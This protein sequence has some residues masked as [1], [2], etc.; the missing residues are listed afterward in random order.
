MP[1]LTD[2]QGTWPFL[3][4]LVLQYPWKPIS[5]SDDL[6]SFVYVIVQCALR[7]HAHNLGSPISLPSTLTKDQLA[8]HNLKYG[9]ELAEFVS[10][11]FYQEHDKGSYVIGGAAKLVQISSSSP[12][13]NLVQVKRRSAIRMHP[14]QQL[15]NDLYSLLHEHYA[16]LDVATLARYKMENN[17]WQEE[18][19]TARAF[20]PQL[21][22]RR[23]MKSTRS[24]AARGLFSVADASL[25]TEE[26][27]VKW[28][29]EAKPELVL[30]NHDEILEIF[31]AVITGMSGGPLVFK[32][33]TEDQLYGTAE[34][35]NERPTGCS[36]AAS[37][38]RKSDATLE[39]RNAKHAR[40]EETSA[41]PL[42]TLE[43]D[44][45]DPRALPDADNVEDVRAESDLTDGAEA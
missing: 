5:L 32:D 19:P 45:K 1:F 37:S 9:S 27:L 42:D 2:V 43:E 36:G 18:D 16:A 13:F 6:E 44:G 34:V 39:G 11:L 35:V 25:A 8:V 3:S 15:L 28:Q 26:Y 12:G 30:D 29:G 33:K 41:Q 10:H 7:F 24:T 21:L 20:E 38:K 31:T 23:Q 22:R 40:I 4:A 14:M 17:N